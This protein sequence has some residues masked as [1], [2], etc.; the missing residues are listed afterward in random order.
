[1]PPWVLVALAVAAVVAL[2]I[3]R[4]ERGGG[5]ADPPA[6]GAHE[7]LPRG[8][9]PPVPPPKPTPAP[10]ARANEPGARPGRTAS[11]AIDVEGI[12]DADERATIA[13]VARAIDRGGPFAY[14]KDGARFANREH[15]LP[16][17]PRGHWRE[18][19]VPTPGEDDR[20]ARRIIAGADGEL[21]YTRDHY[22]TFRRI[23][24]PTAA[25]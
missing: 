23:R 7:R 13:E 6:A 24:A 11:L 9:V 19:T 16:E 15:R 20:G 12:G 17:Q 22:R 25:P 18:Y 1:L 2:I 4:L 5:G 14:R 3:A 21:F 10:P 8:P